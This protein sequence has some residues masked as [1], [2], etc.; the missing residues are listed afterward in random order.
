MHPETKPQSISSSVSAGMLALAYAVVAGLWILLSDTLVGYLF[1]SPVQA[2]RAQ[3][4]KGWAFVVF[5][6]LLL[7]ILVR[8]FADQIR[9]QHRREVEHLRQQQVQSAMLNVIADSSSD[10]IFAKDAE[11]RYLLF[12]NAA[13]RFVGKPA[14]EVLGRDDRGLFPPDQARAIM[15]ID[16]QVQES[17][18]IETNEE[19]L[20]TTSGE[21]VFLATKGPL[22]D[23]QGEVIGSFGISRDITERKH[24]ADA[25]LAAKTRLERVVDN[26]AVGIMFWDWTRGVLIDAND[27]FLQLMGYSREEVAAGILTWQRLT[28][29]EYVERSLAEMAR[30]HDSGRIGPYEK[31]Y[32][33][34]DGS[35]QWLMFA[36]SPLEGPVAV[37]FCVDISELKTAE[38]ELRLRNA[39]LERFNRA[40][41]DR[42]LDMIE[43]KRRVNALSVELGRT[44]PFDLAP[45]DIELRQ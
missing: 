1:D 32:F 22:R 45:F 30:F 6:T 31:E 37:E 5:T 18:R 25:L 8:R 14:E 34:K 42:E 12:N 41:V 20:S 24:A 4:A 9:M 44:P 26:H 40:S 38:A 39:E 7:Y 3:T 28:P 35:R 15:A 19:L 2:A 13:S 21:T 43:L 29:P 27:H 36:G 11:G 16:R 33:R 17:G 10:A 23:A